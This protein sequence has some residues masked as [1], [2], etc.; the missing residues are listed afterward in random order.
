MSAEDRGASLRRRARRWR[1]AGARSPR[2]PGAPV[3]ERQERNDHDVEAE[4][5]TG[6]VLEGLPGRDWLALTGFQTRPGA[7]AHAVVGPAGVYLLTSWS[8]PAEDL[9]SRRSGSELDL[10]VR[11]AV[12]ALAREI[13]SRTGRGAAV[14]AVVVLWSQ[15]PQRVCELDGIA[16]VQGRELAHWMRSRRPELD[17][18]GL[19]EIAQ[20]VAN[21]ASEDARHFPSGPAGQH[22]ASRAAA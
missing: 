18:P 17:H 8:R 19:D 9:L 15:C 6:R 12:D 11:D 14:H 3:P 7:T 21:L 1:L 16:F 2:S 4:R 20:A 22:A 13:R 10:D 5:R